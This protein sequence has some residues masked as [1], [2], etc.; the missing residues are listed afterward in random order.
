MTDQ[1]NKK[2]S[3]QTDRQTSHRALRQVRSTGSNLSPSSNAPATDTTVLLIPGVKVRLYYLSQFTL[4]SSKNNQPNDIK[5]TAS[6]VGRAALS[7]S[8]ILNASIGVQSLSREMIVTP[9]ILDFLEK[10]VEP[11]MTKSGDVDVLVEDESVAGTGS[12]LSSS[13]SGLYSFPVDVVVLIRVQPSDIRFNCSPI[14]KVECLLRIPLLDFAITSTPP[15]SSSAYQRRRNSSK[16]T[17]STTSNISSGSGQEASE[18][19]SGMGF[20]VCLSRFS[21]CVFHP[22]GKQYGN[23]GDARGNSGLFAEQR[24][25]SRSRN[26]P[27]SGKKDSLSLNVEFIKFN[28]SRKTIKSMEDQK[29]SVQI[30]GRTGYALLGNYLLS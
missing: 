8:G 14:S 13:G 27:I 29:T 1:K 25:N 10:A 5:D 22:Y 9:S 16:R 18:V 4:D 3:E 17:A 7:K 19:T 26:Q 12:M 6:S 28:L 30:S 23:A 21:F 20:T 15:L 2:F 24:R 11:I